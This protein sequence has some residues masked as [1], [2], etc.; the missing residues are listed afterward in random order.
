MKAFYIANLT[1]LNTHLNTRLNPLTSTTC[2]AIGGK[3]KNTLYITTADGGSM[4]GYMY[5]FDMQGV[6]GMATGIQMPYASPEYYYRKAT[7]Q[8]RY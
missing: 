1:H 8:Y 3:D 4:G 6:Q 2:V 5:T 7:I